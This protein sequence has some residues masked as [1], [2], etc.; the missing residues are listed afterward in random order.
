MKAAALRAQLES[1]LGGRWPSPFTFR[2]RPAAETVSSGIAQIDSLTGAGG[3]PRGA[4]TEIFGP[5]SSGRTSLLLSLLAQMTAREEACALVDSTDAFDPQSAE[6]AGVDLRRLLWVR[7]AA[8]AGTRDSGL[9]TRGME[10]C[11]LIG[12]WKSS[13]GKKSPIVNQ[14]SALASPEP[15]TPSPES[16]FSGARNVEQSLRATELLLQ[17][18]GFGLVA[19]DLGDVPPQWARR[20]PLAFWFRFRR[21]VENTP[22]VLVVL[23]QAPCAKTCASLVLRLEPHAAQFSVFTCQLSVNRRGKAFN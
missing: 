20:V 15:R 10:D 12:D 11:R 22:T 6:A 18:G 1:E 4:L 23:D 21:A 2:E 5:D 16:R 7:C 17:G 14:Q 9:G 19:V 8:R 13:G 3:L